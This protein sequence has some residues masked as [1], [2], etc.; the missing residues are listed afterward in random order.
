MGGGIDTIHLDLYYDLNST[1]GSTS[2]TLSEN[3]ENLEASLYS[4]T[5]TNYFTLTGNSLANK[6]TVLSSDTYAAANLFG[7]AGNDTLIGGEGDDNLYGDSGADVMQGGNGSDFYYVDNVLDKVIES[8]GALAGTDDSV[9]SSV[10]FTLGANVEIIYLENSSN[11]NATGNALNNR[12][13]G[14]IG[15]NTL[16]GMAGDDT[17]NGYAG[18]DVLNGG[19]GNDKLEIN[20][21]MDPTLRLGSDTLN[22]GAGNDTLYGGYGDRIDKLYGGAGNDL[23]AVYSASDIISDTAGNDTVLT[24]VNCWAI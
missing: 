8:T 10:S 16:N 18:N 15:N 1:T 23:Y 21:S 22:G 12:V 14:N 9:Y 5:G 20:P 3:V 4:Y 11:I 7:G 6:I 2:F 13:E 17:L 19:D 24:H